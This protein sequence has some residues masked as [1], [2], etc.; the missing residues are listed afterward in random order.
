MA[1]DLRGNY[2]TLIAIESTIVKRTHT[3][4]RHAALQG[5]SSVYDVAE[6]NCWASVILRARLLAGQPMNLHARFRPRGCLTHSER[7]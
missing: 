4:W 2:V 5:Q 7:S 1:G 6:Q 3:A